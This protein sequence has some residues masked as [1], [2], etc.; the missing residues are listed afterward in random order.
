MVWP[1]IKNNILRRVRIR[2]RLIII[3]NCQFGVTFVGPNAAGDVRATFIDMHAYT[4]YARTRHKTSMHT[5]AHTYTYTHLT[6]TH[7]P[8]LANKF[9]DRHSYAIH[10]GPSSMYKLQ[11][12]RRTAHAASQP[13]RS[14]E[15]PLKQ[16]VSQNN[17]LGCPFEHTTTH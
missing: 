16:V 5:H 17:P 6:R 12:S 15:S 3:R 7:T 13:V 8:Y 14:N 10:A 9:Y 2:S 11:P 4:Y 1:Y